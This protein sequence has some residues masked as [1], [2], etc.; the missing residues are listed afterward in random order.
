MNDEAPCPI[1]AVSL[2]AHF[3]R[4][5]LTLELPWAGVLRKNAL[6]RSYQTRGKRPALSKV[7]ALSSEL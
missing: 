6:L 1:R 7:E 4:T 5:A 3:C 2:R